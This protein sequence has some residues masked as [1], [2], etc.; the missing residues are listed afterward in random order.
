[1]IDPCQIIARKMLE[2]GYDPKPVLDFI[3]EAT[4][5][6]QCEIVDIG[7]SIFVL[8]YI[9][10]Y[11]IV[12]HLF[13]ED[14]PVVLRKKILIFHNKILERSISKVYIY[15]ENPKLIEL[16]RKLGFTLQI[17]DKSK[18]DWMIDPKCE[19]LHINI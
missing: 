7:K 6:G 2:D 10:P 19:I 17:S 16:L 12:L 18:F 15:G 11:E 9:A 1:M 3:N 14:S 5:T 8:I 4:I 13:S